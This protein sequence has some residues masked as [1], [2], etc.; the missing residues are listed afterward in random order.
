MRAIGVRELKERTSQVLRRV[1]ERG[2]EPETAAEEERIARQ[3]AREAQKMKNRLA[4]KPSRWQRF[5]RYVWDKK[6]G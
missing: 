4:Q 5:V 6:R 2:E 1:R 3:K